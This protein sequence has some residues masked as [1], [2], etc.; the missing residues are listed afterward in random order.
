MTQKEQNQAREIEKLQVV[1]KRIQQRNQRV[2]REKAWETS[3]MRK[4]ILVVLT[5]LTVVIFFWAAELPE[6]FINALV[7]TLALMLSNLS[8]PA[9]K[10]AWLKHRHNKKITS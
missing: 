1:I 4:L 6:P 2:E 3:T 8:L 9:F 5:Y 7:P 10:K